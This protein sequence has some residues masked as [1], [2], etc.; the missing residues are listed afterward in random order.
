MLQWEYRIE[1]YMDFGAIGEESRRANIT[2]QL[3][4]LGGE[5]WELVSVVSGPVGTTEHM[6]SLLF[7][8]RVAAQ[9]GGLGQFVPSS[10]EEEV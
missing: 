6:Y 8:R 2:R 1:A 9:F 7:K 4:T 10:D 3:N 5:G